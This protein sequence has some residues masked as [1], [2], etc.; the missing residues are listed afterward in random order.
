[1]RKTDSLNV[2]W[3]SLL[4]LNVEDVE[5]LS[6][7]VK[8]RAVSLSECLLAISKLGDPGPGKL[9]SFE[10]ALRR[11]LAEKGIRKIPDD[12]LIRKFREVMNRMTMRL[13]NRPFEP[14]K[15]RDE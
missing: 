1:M 11:Y 2:V 6:I 7:Y 10:G 5:K 14:P 9:F 13:F 15:G 12:P 4:V 8:S 3:P